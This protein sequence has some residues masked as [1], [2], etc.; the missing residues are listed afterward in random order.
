VVKCEEVGIEKEIAG[1]IGWAKLKEI[2]P[3]VTEKNKDHW[4]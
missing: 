1:Q 3:V 4:I 2:V